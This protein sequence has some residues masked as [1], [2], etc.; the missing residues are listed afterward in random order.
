MTR[1][2]IGD[3]VIKNPS[4]WVVCEFDGWGRGM[5]V[6]IVVEPPFVLDADEVDV[7]WPGGRCFEYESQLQLA[8]R[9]DCRTGNR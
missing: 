5:G 1:F 4:T 3:Q 8:E 9:A 2:H 7:R 6:G